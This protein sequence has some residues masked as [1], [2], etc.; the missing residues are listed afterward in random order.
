MGRNVRVL[1]P[2][3][4]WEWR[5]CRSL[6]RRRPREVTTGAGRLAGGLR[7]VQRFTSAGVGLMAV[8]PLVI[9]QVA[10]ELSEWAASTAARMKDADQ[11]R[12]AFLLGHAG[13]L[14]A[15]LRHLHQELHAVVRELRL[16]RADWPRARREEIARRLLALGAQPVLFVVDESLASLREWTRPEASRPSLAR[17]GT[18]N[19]QRIA[20]LVQLL[21]DSATVYDHWFGE[22]ESRNYIPSYADAL[23]ERS[24]AEKE[25]RD[26]SAR[27]LREIQ[28]LPLDEV[29]RAFGS[30][31]HKCSACIRSSPNLSGRPCC[32]RPRVECETE[33]ACPCQRLVSREAVVFARRPTRVRRFLSKR[34]HGA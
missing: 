17:R 12:A 13:I 33:I 27:L 22:D 15:A 34:R 6:S 9:L 10:K 8:E 23:L 29:N 16:Y 11:R 2:D 32:G 7:E 3:P 31:A 19:R 14:V 25:V 28:E 20:E 5:P 26:V 24:H 1:G 4:V 30:C 21:A 18:R